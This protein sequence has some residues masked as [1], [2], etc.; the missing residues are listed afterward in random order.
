MRDFTTA[1]T[2]HNNFFYLV[3]SHTSD[4]R[5]LSNAD[6][7]SVLLKFASILEFESHIKVVYLEYRNIQQSFSQ[8]QVSNIDIY[9]SS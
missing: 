8:V 6:G 2:Q 9:R 1:V 7:T 3:D 5:G 4:M